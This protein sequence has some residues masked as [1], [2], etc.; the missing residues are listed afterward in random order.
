MWHMYEGGHFWGMHWMWWTLWITILILIF[1]VPLG[2]RPKQKGEAT[3][4]DL[5]KKR[6][7]N[8]EIDKEEYEER[9]KILEEK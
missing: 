9:K 7:A 3:A 8:G 2:F 4:L 5:L 1:F 6:F